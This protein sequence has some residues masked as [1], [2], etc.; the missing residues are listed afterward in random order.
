M[1]I[2]AKKQIYI[3][4]LWAYKLILAICIE[5]SKYAC[6]WPMNI[7]S[8]NIK[9]KMRGMKIVK[10]AEKYF[11]S[12]IFLISL[13]LINFKSNLCLKQLLSK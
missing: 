8:R 3:V 7:M 2:L 6:L 13:C 4:Y 1:P 5:V 11:C 12:S 10:N 9:G